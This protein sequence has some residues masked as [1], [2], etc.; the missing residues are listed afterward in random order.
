MFTE[1]SHKTAEIYHVQLTRISI[2]GSALI[3]PIALQSVM[4]FQKTN[5]KVIARDS[6]LC[7]T[8]LTTVKVMTLLI[9]TF[10]ITCT[11]EPVSRRVMCVCLVWVLFLIALINVRF[12]VFTQTEAQIRHS[13]IRSKKVISRK[14]FAI[15]T[16][17]C[18][19][20]AALTQY[21]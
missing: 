6:R 4:R 8:S 12:L 20:M 9:S 11:V 17:L 18:Q 7:F 3:Q 16:G 14:H 2:T 15:S 5:R 1:D 19:E 10:Y 21:N 13:Y